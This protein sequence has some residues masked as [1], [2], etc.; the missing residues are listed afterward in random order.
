MNNSN[1]ENVTLSTGFGAFYMYG[2]PWINWPISITLSTI[3]SISCFRKEP[4]FNSSWTECKDF[5]PSEKGTKF[6]E[7]KK[8]KEKQESEGDSDYFDILLEKEALSFS[9]TRISLSRKYNHFD[10]FYN[11]NSFFSFYLLTYELLK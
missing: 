8:Q 1:V 9:K 2:F 6:P 11:L 10:H 5:V 4:S 3:K 7:K